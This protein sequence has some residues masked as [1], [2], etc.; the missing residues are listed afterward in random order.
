VGVCLLFRATGQRAA[1]EPWGTPDHGAANRQQILGRITAAVAQEFARLLESGRGKNHCAQLANRLLEFCRREAAPPSHL[2]LNGL[3]SGLN[4]L[5]QCALGDDIALQL[6]L[7]ADAGGAKAD[8]GRIELILMQLALSAREIACAG[9]F[10][11]RTSVA[12]SEDTG[13]GYAIVTVT[14]PAALRDFP[15]LDEIVRQ[16]Q[17][18]IRLSFE[19]GS[20]KIYLPAAAA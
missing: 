20:V 19:D 5:L 1:D 9:D 2:D 18:E 17:G 3:I 6:V 8:P 4:D 12:S 13:D 14:P 15:S 10:F 11:V 7:E 16:S